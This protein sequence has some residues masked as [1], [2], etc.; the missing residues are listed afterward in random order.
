VADETVEQMGACGLPATLRVSAHLKPES[1]SADFDGDGSLDIAA[2]VVRTSDG[3][4]GIAICRA[5]TWLHLLGVDDAQV[6]DL[7][8]GYFD[9]VDLWHLY[10]MSEIGSSTV[11]ALGLVGDSLFLGRDNTFRMLI[12]WDG[13]GFL[14]SDQGG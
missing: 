6:G 14:A 7:D 2:P 9:T 11:K 13:E 4:R 10:P 1:F 8:P 12:Y 3:R 5:G